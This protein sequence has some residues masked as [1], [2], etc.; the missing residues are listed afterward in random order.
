MPQL[1]HRRRLWIRLNVR[2]SKSLRRV[3]GVP[4]LASGLESSIPGLHFAGAV[5]ANFGPL[6]RF[7]AGTGYAGR[8]ITRHVMSS[9]TAA[10]LRAQ[11]QGSLSLRDQDGL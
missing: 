8:A 7:V 1:L 6:V 11:P 9:R 4:E 3:N 10:P 2:C 5:A